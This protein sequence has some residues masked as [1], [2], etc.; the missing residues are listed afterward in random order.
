[1]NSSNLVLANLPETAEHPARVAAALGAPLHLMLVLLH[2]D[3]YSVMLE[4]ELVVASAEQTARNE[5][6]TVAGLQ[7]LATRLPGLT[8]VAESAGILSNAVEEAVAHYYP[9]LL[10]IGLSPEH[11][12]AD[13]WLHNQVL[14][15]LRA[16]Q[17][18]LLL[19]AT[20]EAPMV[21]LTDR[22]AT[23]DEFANALLTGLSPA[24]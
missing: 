3:V 9:L 11:D 12:L 6:K 15:V 13:H 19:P 18:P 16:K 4:P 22:T 1:M 10:M 7:D 17:R 8:E 21:F 2:L 24:S 20:A 5:A 14:S 23:I